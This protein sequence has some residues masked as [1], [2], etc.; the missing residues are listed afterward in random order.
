MFIDLRDP[1]G[2]IKSEY[3][4]AIVV[5][6]LK[7][8]FECDVH[9]VAPGSVLLGYVDNWFLLSPHGSATHDTR[10]NNLK[11]VGSAGGVWM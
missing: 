11:S 8:A 2:N 3:T 10:W 4:Y 7:W 1:F 6:V 5:A 9:I